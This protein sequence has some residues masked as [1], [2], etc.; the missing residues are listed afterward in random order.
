MLWH[1]GSI[2]VSWAARLVAIDLGGEPGDEKDRP[3]CNQ[4]CAG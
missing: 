2:M 3:E 1:S 4:S